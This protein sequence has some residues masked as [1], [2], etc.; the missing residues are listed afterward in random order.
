M[1]QHPNAEFPPK[2]RKPAERKLFL[3]EVWG[4]AIVGVR[5][6]KL[7]SDLGVSPGTVSKILNGRMAPSLQLGIKMAAMLGISV[8]EL[9]IK[10]QKAQEAMKDIHDPLRRYPIP[11]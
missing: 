1:S 11:D 8:P 7:A 2:T 5:V 4:D 3:Y 10:V 9:Y 6:R